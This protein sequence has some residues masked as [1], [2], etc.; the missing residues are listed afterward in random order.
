MRCR[1]LPLWLRSRQLYVYLHA[2]YAFHTFGCRAYFTNQR[3]GIIL[4]QQKLNVDFGV[5]IDVDFLNLL[6][7]NYALTGTRMLDLFEGCTH[8]IENDLTI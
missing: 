1:A 5:F 6:V 8:T 4:V 7:F 3:P 2:G